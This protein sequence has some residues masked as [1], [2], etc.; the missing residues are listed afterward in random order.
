MNKS[1]NME[2]SKKTEGYS[3]KVPEFLPWLEKS[4]ATKYEQS[5]HGVK[6]RFL[7]IF[8]LFRSLLQGFLEISEL[9]IY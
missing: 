7:C 3:L 5:L 1:Q 6:A 8:S 4:F 9:V 2:E